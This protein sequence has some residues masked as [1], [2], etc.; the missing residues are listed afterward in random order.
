MKQRRINY[1]AKQKNQTFS[2]R[3]HHGRRGGWIS[4]WHVLGAQNRPGAERRD[5]SGRPRIADG[6]GKFQRTGR[7][8]PRRRRQYPGQQKGKPGWI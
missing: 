5:V 2:N 7:T 1:E 8:G 6:A 4:V 3:P